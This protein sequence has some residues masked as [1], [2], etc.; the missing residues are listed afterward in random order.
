MQVV[1]DAVITVPAH[2][3][4]TQRRATR[5]A[6][7]IA[8]LNI[9]RLINEPTA[10]FLTYAFEKNTKKINHRKNVLIFNLGAGSLD[11]SIVSTKDGIFEVK[12]TAG[13]AHLGG[14]DFDRRLVDHFVQEFKRKHKMDVG[15]DKNALHRLHVACKQAK[16][17]LYRL[18]KALIEV[19]SLCPGINF[20]AA[21]TRDDFEQLNEDLFRRTVDPVERAISDA[22]VEKANIH[23]VIL[24]G[25]SSCL[26]GVKTHLENFFDGRLPLHSFLNPEMAAACGAGKYFCT[27]LK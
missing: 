18:N 22:M 5:D 8:G 17:T 26:L 10:A 15:G 9:L 16:C 27:Y 4:D 23:T 3:N 19:D 1:E 24:V 20:E 7:T 25:G 2:F 6:A 11:V 21:I 14:K 13:D 12:S